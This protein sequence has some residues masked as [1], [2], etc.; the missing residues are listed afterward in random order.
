[1]APPGGDSLAVLLP[2]PN[3]RAGV[4]WGR[5][6][7]ALRDALVADLE[8]PFGLEGLARSVVVEHRM[9]PPDFAREFGAVDGNAFAVEPTLHQSRV[10]PRAQPRPRVRGLYHVGGGTHPG[11][12]DPG[13]AAR[14]AGD[15]F[16]RAPRTRGDDGCSRA[17]EAR[18]TT[19]RVARTFSIA[20]RCS[21]ATCVTT[22]TCSTWSSARSTT[23]STKVAPRRLSAWRRS[24][25]GAAGEPV[26]RSREVDILDD[27][28]A[29][30]RRFRARRWPTSA[31]ACAKTSPGADFATEA[32]RR[33]LLLPG[34]RTVGLVMAVR[35]SGR[36]ALDRASPAAAALGMAMQRTN[37][38]RD[39]D[40]DAAN[41][42]V[43]IARETIERFGGELAPGRREALLRD[44]IA[45]RRRALRTRPGGHRR[46]APRPPGDRG[47]GRDVPRDP[48]PDSSARATARA[49]AAPSSRRAAQAARGG[50]APRG[51]H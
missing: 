42:R 38:L 3:L 51:A 14:R 25:R 47:R 13:G 20:C 30:S 26:A 6:A 17:A 37:I 49:P 48:A 36:R 32:G 40:E 19:S 7:D 44:Q 5:E 22:S 41:G 46:A 45:P 9:A 39:I 27:L 33:P 34:G 23:W 1:M 50:D 18:A 43:Y 31:R 8:T 28:D 11:R 12:G 2:V 29:A 4:D 10:L 24:R 21:R 35:C 16:A 15:R